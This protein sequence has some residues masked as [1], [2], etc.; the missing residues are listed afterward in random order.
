MQGDELVIDDADEQSIAGEFVID[1]ES[2]E[3]VSS[4]RRSSRVSRRSSRVSR[5]SL[6][7]PLLARSESGDEDEVYFHGHAG[8]KS[9]K[10][11]IVT[12]DLTIVIAGFSSSPIRMALYVLACVSSLGLAYLL[13]RWLPRWRVSVLG[14]STSLRECT[15]V[16]VEVSM[17]TQICVNVAMSSSHS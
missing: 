6:Q 11:Y 17:P 2:A 15:W 8:I 1:I 3:R 9:Q 14:S 16:V 12:D 4:S 10:I 5:R 7:D 13:F